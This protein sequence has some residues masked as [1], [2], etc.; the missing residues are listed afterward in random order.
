MEIYHG[1]C[2]RDGV[3]VL[4]EVTDLS[5]TSLVQKVKYLSWNPDNI[6]N[7]KLSCFQALNY[8]SNK[9][10]EFFSV[11]NLFP[12]SH[13]R[14]DVRFHRKSSVKLPLWSPKRSID[15]ITTNSGKSKYRWMAKEVFKSWLSPVPF[16][17]KILPC[18]YQKRTE[19]SQ[20]DKIKYFLSSSILHFRVWCC[21]LESVW[22]NDKRERIETQ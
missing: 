1:E 2:A 21:G 8:T 15:T 22:V 10:F 12:S 6:F 17:P 18:G 5:S 11:D 7:Y 3:F 13:Y 16:K 4:V 14:F 19:E 9:T 20:T